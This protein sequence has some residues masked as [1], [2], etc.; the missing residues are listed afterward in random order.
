MVAHLRP[1]SGARHHFRIPEPATT[2]RSPA[3]VHGISFAILFGSG[4]LG[5]HNAVDGY[6]A[7]IAVAG[8]WVVARWI[9]RVG[10]RR[11]PL[12][13]PPSDAWRD[14]TNF[15]T[16]ECKRGPTSLW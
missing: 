10:T 12:V 9:A 14:S 6:A 4:H 11:F 5:W 1:I 2:V 3:C 7:M 8:L 16:R 15:A 13:Q